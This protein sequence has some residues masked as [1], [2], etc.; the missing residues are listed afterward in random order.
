MAS[1]SLAGKTALITGGTSGIGLVTARELAR[2]GANVVLVGR[3][4]DKAERARTAIQA[5][6]GEKA[7]VW[8]KCYDLSLI[9][10]VQA[11]A[12]E[13]LQ[14]HS[15][16]DIL[17]NNAGIMPGVLHITE[18]G[19]E[20]SWATNHLAP[21]ALTNLMLPLLDA[22]GKARVVTVSSIA[23][24][25]GEIEPN[26]ETRNSP[27]KYSWLTAYADSKLANILFTKELAHRLDLTGI[28]ANCLHP[29][30]V[31]TGLIRT[32]TSAV[33]KGLW[34]AARPLMISPEQGAQTTLYLATSPEVASVSGRY[35]SNRRPARCS[36]RANNP[37]EASRLWKISAEETGIE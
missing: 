30:M 37:T 3:D 35:F 15:Q 26:R 4:A 16:L 2:Q 5:A 24:W 33:M 11:L 18:E 13:M 17:V 7:S 14:E 34:W 23:H 9:R 10:N 27:D 8:V 12:D 32:D 21:Y 36:S 22:A 1:F 20:L 6:A 25:V 31:D 19:H 29:G 28:T